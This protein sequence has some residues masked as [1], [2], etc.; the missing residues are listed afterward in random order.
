MGV[1][2][3]TYTPQTRQAVSERHDMPSRSQEPQNSRPVLKGLAC[4][5]CH[6]HAFGILLV[7]D[8]HLYLRRDHCA[9]R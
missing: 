8:Y 5:N 7:T 6:H 1:Y 9:N 3:A 4:R 2:I